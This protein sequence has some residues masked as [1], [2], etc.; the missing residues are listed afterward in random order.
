MARGQ[1]G[2]APPIGKPGTYNLETRNLNISKDYVLL[3]LQ[4]KKQKVELTVSINQVNNILI[5]AKTLEICA[6]QIAKCEKAAEGAPLIKAE[7]LLAKAVAKHF[8]K[9]RKVLVAQAKNSKGRPVTTKSGQKVMR[10]TGS[11]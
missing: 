10:I 11:A 7:E 4:D 2:F 3:N 6:P 1:R 9:P 8:E 5:L